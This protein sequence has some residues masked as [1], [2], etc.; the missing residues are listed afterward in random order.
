M[1]HHYQM[2]QMKNPERLFQKYHYFQYFPM[3]QK[4]HHRK[5]YQMYRLNQLLQ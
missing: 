1:Y 4:L 3:Y 5:M 2:Y